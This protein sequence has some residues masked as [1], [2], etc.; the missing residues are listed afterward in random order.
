MAN[1]EGLKSAGTLTGQVIT[2]SSGLLAFTVTF[3]EKFTPRSA[4][5]LTAPIELKISWL[6]L[7]V[8]IVFAFWTSM[9]L[10]GTLIEIDAGRRQVS[11]SQASSRVPAF[12]MFLFFVGGVISL[13]VAGWNLTT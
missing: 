5:G 2:V 9:A 10:T 11:D 12:L 3:V 4:P 6:C 13:V 1:L 7:I 8:A